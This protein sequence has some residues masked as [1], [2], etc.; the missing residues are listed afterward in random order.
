MPETDNT[1]AFCAKFRALADPTRLAIFTFICGC[2]P[3]LEYS[4][5]SGDCRSACA[6]VSDVCCRF[7]VSP[8]TVS[9]HL[10]ELRSAGLVHTEKRGKWVYVSVDC[11]AVAELAAFLTGMCHMAAPGEINRK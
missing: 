8:S 1:A 7:P 4:E 3:D 10:K 11:G 5:A 9:H 2:G 6:C